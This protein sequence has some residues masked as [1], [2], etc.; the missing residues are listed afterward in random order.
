M[1]DKVLSSF[2]KI[3]GVL[4]VTV[5]L[6]LSLAFCARPAHAQFGGDIDIPTCAALSDAMLVTVALRTE[7]VPEEKIKR[8]LPHIYV[9]QFLDQFM[10][11]LLALSK[12]AKVGKDNNAL[13]QKFADACVAA[14]VNR[15][16]Q[17]SLVPIR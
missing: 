15:Y 14:V 3:M 1:N 7:G 13:V 16:N 9:Q 2:V 6:F 10:K 5:V 12:S 17:E 11:D 8:I 4:L